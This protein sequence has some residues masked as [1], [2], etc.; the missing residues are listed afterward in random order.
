M[1]VNKYIYKYIYISLSKR[2]YIYILRGYI[3]GKA[4][5]YVHKNKSRPRHS[6][7]RRITLINLCYFRSYFRLFRCFGLA[8]LLLPLL[9]LLPPPC[10]N[11]GDSVHFP[12]SQCDDSTVAQC[13]R[14]LHLHTFAYICINRLNLHT[15]PVRYDLLRHD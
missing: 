7:C 11:C 14:R 13:H 6:P 5:K 8:S 2:K 9:L 15:L 3:S 12:M 1:R 10:G 4:P